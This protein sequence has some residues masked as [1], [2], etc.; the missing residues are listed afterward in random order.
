MSAAARSYI[1]TD[2]NSALT[3]DAIEWSD[4]APIRE[5]EPGLLQSRL[6]ASHLSLRRYAIR[7]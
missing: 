1:V 4:D 3:Y 2:L 5:I 6:I 7:L